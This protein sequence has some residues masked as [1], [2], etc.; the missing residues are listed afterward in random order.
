M[1]N[2]VFSSLILTIVMVLFNKHRNWT[3]KRN[4]RPKYMDIIINSLVYVNPWC[5]KWNQLF[6][7]INRKMRT[8]SIQ[9]FNSLRIIIIIIIIQRSMHSHQQ[10]ESTDWMCA[11][12]CQYIKLTHTHNTTAVSY[13]LTVSVSLLVAVRSPGWTPSSVGWNNESII[14]PYNPS[15]HNVSG[16]YWE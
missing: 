16:T 10:N 12:N 7:S 6:L 1:Y 5:N 2:A 14:T 4:W 3:P 9:W 11:K 15:D 8:H 13:S